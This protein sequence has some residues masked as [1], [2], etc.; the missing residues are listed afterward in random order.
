MSNYHK[1]LALAL[2][3]SA[4]ISLLYSEVQDTLAHIDAALAILRQPEA[5]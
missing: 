3:L 5:V 2:L 1:T 4:Q